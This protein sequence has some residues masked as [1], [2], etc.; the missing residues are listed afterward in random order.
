MKAMISVLLLCSVALAAQAGGDEHTGD[1][2]SDRHSGTH[3]DSQ[4]DGGPDDE[5]TRQ[6]LREAERALSE[7]A[8]Q[9]AERRLAL[10]GDREATQREI[11]S[12]GAELQRAARDLARIYRDMLREESRQASRMVAQR[13][14]I[15]VILGERTDQGYVI[16]GLSPGGPAET[17]GI[18]S[19]DVLTAI[20]GQSLAQHEEHI[21]ALRHALSSLEP[22]ES[23]VVTVLRDDEEH[24]FE[25][26]AVRTP[27][28]TLGEFFDPQEPPVPPLPPEAPDVERIQ[29]QLQ[30]VEAEV[31]RIQHEVQRELHE[32]LSD[33]ELHRIDIPR[34]IGLAWSDAEG[35]EWHRFS[36][37][38]S[39]ALASVGLWDRNHL[40]NGLELHPLTDGLAPYFATDQGILVLQASPDNALEL[41]TGDVLLA[42]AGTALNEPSDLVRH[43]REMETDEDW[44][45]EVM[46]RGERRQWS[47]SP[48]PD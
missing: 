39:D 19:G 23:V 15:G 26:Q 28:M 12:A 42:V 7:A 14:M 13:G 6:A 31:H 32:Q 17:A 5:A 8:S 38:T 27:R 1:R 29:R 3:P 40:L 30:A 22:G 35:L 44:T 18:R 20:N 21:P 25:L 48:P 33:I 47:V 24:I 36:D 10:Q 16:N 46:R 2:H 34:A 11:R 45:L 37:I 41:E 9:L 4:S 43:L